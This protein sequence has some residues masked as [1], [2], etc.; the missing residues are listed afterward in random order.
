MCEDFF[1]QY[2]S[3]INGPTQPVPSVMLFASTECN[4]P[5]YPLGPGATFVT[6]PFTPGQ[7]VTD[8]TWKV[9]GQLGN[10]KVAAFFV[11]FNFISVKMVS[12]GGRVSNILGPFFLTNTATLNWQNN[13]AAVGFADMFS[14]PIV[15]MT[16]TYIQDWPSQALVTMCMGR[17]SYIGSFPITS[18]APQTENC[19]TFMTN[20]WCANNINNPEC[21]CFKELPAVEAKSIEF[22]AN[23]PVICFGQQCATLRTYK[24]N[25]MLLSPCNL[26]ICLQTIS[27]SPG[28]IDVSTDVIFC[29]GRFFNSSGQLP[30][31]P[32]VTA[33]PAPTEPDN[34]TP[35][36]VWIMLAAAGLLFLVL[37]FLLF[38]EKPTSQSN[39]LQEIKKI[40]ANSANNM[41]NADP[42]TQIGI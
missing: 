20:T 3:F 11:P 34:G 40:K 9:V 26:T 14:D 7:T 29:G 41:N 39:I 24:T 35:F 15:S 33:L 10:N 23:L 13:E 5:S 22:K 25:G 38:S 19:D 30:T 36:Y 42:E 6:N 12:A 2:L 28:I 27:E 17:T 16:F 21:A 8:T 31:Q 1:S 37:I 18:W 32:S 4:S